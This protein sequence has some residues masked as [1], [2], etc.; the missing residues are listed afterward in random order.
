[1]TFSLVVLTALL[2][3]AP[4]SSPARDQC[5]VQ[6]HLTQVFADTHMRALWDKWSPEQRI[7][8]LR[9]ISDNILRDPAR[10][11]SLRWV[12][13]DQVKHGMPDDCGSAR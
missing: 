1:M 13:D 9:L 10:L 5:I 8:R 11:D 4:T 12:Y 7:H 3:S 6:H 2:I